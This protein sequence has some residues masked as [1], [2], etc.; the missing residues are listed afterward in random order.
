MA[1]YIEQPSWS[2][3]SNDLMAELGLDHNG[4]CPLWKNFSTMEEFFH[5]GRIFPQWKNLTTMEEFDHFGSK[6]VLNNN[7]SRHF[8]SFVLFGHKSKHKS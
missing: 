8:T 3:V 2:S 4:I 1:H 6:T 7:N 5:N